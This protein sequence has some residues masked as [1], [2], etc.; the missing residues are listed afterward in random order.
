M[1]PLIVRSAPD[2]PV[3][4]TLAMLLPA[5]AACPFAGFPYTP[6]QASLRL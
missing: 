4:I 3:G 2:V 5:T 1:I 6:E